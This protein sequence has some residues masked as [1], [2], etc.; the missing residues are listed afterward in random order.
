MA[1]SASRRASH[2][3]GIRSQMPMV[4]SPCTL[5]WP[6]TGQAPAPRRPTLPLS[7]R[8]LTTC[9]IV[10]T[11]C[12]CCV[13]PIAQQAMIAFAP[14]AISAAARISAEDTPLAAVT[15]AQLVELK[16]AAT[17]ANPAV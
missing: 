8:K 3:S 11:A 17:A 1:N 9:W 2:D 15:A 7:S 4:R 5:E 10:A 13:R 16:S 14:I 6:R 12:G